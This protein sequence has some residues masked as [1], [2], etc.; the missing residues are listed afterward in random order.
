MDNKGLESNN[1]IMIDKTLASS[2]ANVISGVTNSFSTEQALEENDISSTISANK[3]IDNMVENV[4][5]VRADI[6]DNTTIDKQNWDNWVKRFDEFDKT[7]I[8]A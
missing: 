6:T 4:N 3:N 7:A 1:T 8:K 5:E 2:M